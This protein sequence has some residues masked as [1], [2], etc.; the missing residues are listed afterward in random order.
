ML[1]CV[2]IDGCVDSLKSGVLVCVD[3]CVLELGVDG[4]VDICQQQ[5][6]N[7]KKPQIHMI[8]SCSV[9]TKMGST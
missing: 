6:Y 8:K 5:S 1:T 3:R 4:C 9:H 7:R 2:L